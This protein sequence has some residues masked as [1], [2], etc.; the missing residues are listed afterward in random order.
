[1]NLIFEQ[2]LKFER[3]SKCEHI[4]NEKKI[5]LILK[6]KWILKFENQNFKI[7]KLYGFKIL[8]RNFKSKHF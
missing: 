5:E 3:I 2:I 6:N 1:M 8:N 7:L 4:L